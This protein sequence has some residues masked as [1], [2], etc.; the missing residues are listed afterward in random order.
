MVGAEVSWQVAGCRWQVKVRYIF[1]QALWKYFKCLAMCRSKWHFFVRHSLMK[2][3]KVPI[4][5]ALSKKQ[6]MPT[7][8]SA[9]ISICRIW[10]KCRELRALSLWLK[11][12]NLL[13]LSHFG[14]NVANYTLC[15]ILVEMSRITRFVTFWLKCRELHAL[16]HFGWNVAIYVFPGT[17]CLLPG[18]SNYS[19]PLL[20]AQLQGG[21]WGF[22][23]YQPR[24]TERANI[25]IFLYF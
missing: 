16:S 20:R 13:A 1:C 17:K 21:H 18:T 11:C 3:L 19:A 23:K 12:S 5:R 8:G 14:W 2:I 24:F 22:E 9:N 6:W 25:N 4:A 10:L 15:R 7:G